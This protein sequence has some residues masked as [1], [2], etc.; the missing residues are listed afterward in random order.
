MKPV[1]RIRPSVKAFI[2][3]AG[4]ILVVKEKVIDDG[5]E[6]IIHDVPGG[7]IEPGESSH[8]ALLREV[9]EEV[10]LTIE[11]QHPVGNWDFVLH[12]PKESIRIVCSGYQCALIGKPTTNITK[13]PAQYEDIIEV[14]WLTKEEILQ[15]T[16]ILRNPDMRKALERVVV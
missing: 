15:S 16:E 6:K 7:G 13:N 4:K 9:I 5:L 12:K 8:D 2:I 11:V 3:H 10:G 14:L 1:V